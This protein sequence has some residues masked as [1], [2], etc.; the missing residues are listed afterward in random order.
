[1]E[2]SS[3]LSD[4]V[5][6]FSS[7]EIDDI[8]GMLNFNRVVF[9]SNSEHDVRIYDPEGMEQLDNLVEQLFD[10]FEGIVCTKVPT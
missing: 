10:G 7:Q 1:M 5:N 4:A 6:D 9:F 3:I 8:L 2:L